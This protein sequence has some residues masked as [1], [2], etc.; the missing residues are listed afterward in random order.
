MPVRR[1]APDSSAPLPDWAD[2]AL[3]E[4]TRV[5]ILFPL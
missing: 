5:R 3:G 1:L 2:Q 4:V